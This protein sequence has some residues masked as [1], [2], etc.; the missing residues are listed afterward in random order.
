MAQNRLQKLLIPCVLAGFCV[1]L[2]SPEAL[3]QIRKSCSGEVVLKASAS[4]AAQ[5]SL[6]QTEVLGPKSVAKFSSEWDG[7]A[8][9]LWHEDEKS[10]VWHGL[11][12]VDLEKAPGRYEWKVSWPGPGGESQ[13]CSVFVTVHAGKFPT[14]RLNSGKA[15]CAARSRAGKAR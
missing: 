9:P 13:S 3:A 2:G 11:L 10:A 15:I 12:G 5:G 1:A 7:R 8:I 4:I 6:L 14:E